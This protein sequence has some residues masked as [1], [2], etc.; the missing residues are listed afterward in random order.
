[1]AEGGTGDDTLTVAMI[2]MN[3]HQRDRHDEDANRVLVGV[4]P[5]GALGLRWLL[6]EVK[7]RD[8]AF[9][10]HDYPVLL[11]RLRREVVDAAGGDGAPPPVQANGAVHHD[12]F[13]RILEEAAAAR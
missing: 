2:H 6:D 13:A 10:P 4:D 3:K 1:V 9:L 8:G 7:A 12:E 11:E 5:A